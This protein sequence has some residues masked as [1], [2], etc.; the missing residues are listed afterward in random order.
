MLITI[1]V[2]FLLQMTYP[3]WGFDQTWPILLI[4]I[5]AV[6]LAQRMI[7]HRGHAP[8]ERR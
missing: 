5:G 1:G 8:E 2:L 6:M 7:P 3:G 4:A